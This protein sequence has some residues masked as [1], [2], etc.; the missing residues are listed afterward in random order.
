MGFEGSLTS[1]SWLLFYLV[2]FF[3]LVCV[4]LFS[5][6]AFMKQKRSGVEHD[7]NHSE[8]K[9]KQVQFFSVYSGSTARH[10]LPFLLSSI[11]CPSRGYCL[12]RMQ[13]WLLPRH[14]SMVFHGQVLQPPPFPLLKPKFPFTHNNA[15]A[16]SVL[17]SFCLKDKY[18]LSLYDVMRIVLNEH[19]ESA[20]TFPLHPGVFKSISSGSE[21]ANGNI[22]PTKMCRVAQHRVHRTTFLCQ[23]MFAKFS[24]GWKHKI[25]P[26]GLQSLCTVVRT[27]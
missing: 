19:T 10:S 22:K 16:V 25:H 4:R 7:L 20:S 14:L 12:K 9:V 5:F 6:H 11:W 17:N 27:N 24:L 26:A 23:F 13:L 2:C 3:Y 18:P 1:F 21:N 15:W 8:T